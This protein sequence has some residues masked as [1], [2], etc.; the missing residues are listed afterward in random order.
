MPEKIAP[1]NTCNLCGDAGAVVV[2]RKG[3]FGVPLRNVMCLRCTLVWVDP[4][5]GSD[6][7][8]AWYGEHYHDQYS[9]VGLIG[10]DGSV[11]AP[12]TAE[13]ERLLR[14]GLQARVDAVARWTDIR[15]TS[16][17]RVLEVGCRDGRLLRRLRDTFQA[18][19]QGVEPSVKESALCVARGVPCFT[20]R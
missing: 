17:P 11:V 18:R 13:H 8:A 12:G 19:V 3:R 9:R 6:E 4:R 2:G 1:E 5:P 20:A 10:R 15:T 7:L 14:E 16:R